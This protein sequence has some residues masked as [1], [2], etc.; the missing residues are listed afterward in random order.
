MGIPQQFTMDRPTEELM[1]H[2][3]DHNEVLCS[4]LHG[5]PYEASYGAHYAMIDPTECAME[6]NMGCPMEVTI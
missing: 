5:T 4:I 1:G 2:P 3:V 6:V